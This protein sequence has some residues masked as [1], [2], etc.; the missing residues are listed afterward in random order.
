MKTIA[1]D[2]AEPSSFKLDNQY[3]QKNIHTDFLQ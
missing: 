1:T 3:S 2:D